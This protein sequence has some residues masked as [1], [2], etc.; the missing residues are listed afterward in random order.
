MSPDWTTSDNSMTEATVM[1]QS[2]YPDIRI[3]GVEAGENA[4]WEQRIGQMQVCSIWFYHVQ[5]GHN[6]MTRQCNLESMQ[7]IVQVRSV[8]MGHWG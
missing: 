1:Y 2:R 3:S 8:N 5:G 7:D 4:Q 6:R